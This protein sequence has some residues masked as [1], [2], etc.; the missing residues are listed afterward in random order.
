MLPNVDSSASHGLTKVS[1]LLGGSYWLDAVP[2]PDDPRLEPAQL[3]AAA[4]DTLRLHFPHVDLP[5]PAYALTSTHR[6]CIPQVPPGSRPQFRAFGERLAQAGGVAVVGG[7]YASVG[8]NGAVKSAWEV[9]TSFAKAVNEGDEAHEAEKKAREVV[10]TGTEM[11]Q[12]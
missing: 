2:A 12:L 3:V 5:E 8:M 7:G 6:D 10:K 11:W 9:G 1:L 4:L